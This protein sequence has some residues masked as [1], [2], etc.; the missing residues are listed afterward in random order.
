MM[1]T[2]INL[3]FKNVYQNYRC[4]LVHLTML[5]TLL[6]TNYYRSMKSTTEMSVKGK[7]YTPAIIELVLIV[8]CICVSLFVLAYE[9]YYMVR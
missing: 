2:M 7:I 1:Y 4:S 3:P 9:I 6:T 8:A 5:Y